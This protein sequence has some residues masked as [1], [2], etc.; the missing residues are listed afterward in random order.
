MADG[1]MLLTGEIFRGVH[2]L[3]ASFHLDTERFPALGTIQ[4]AI[5]RRVQAEIPKQYEEVGSLRLA[6]WRGGWQTDVAGR[7]EADIFE[8]R[9]AT[10][11]NIGRALVTVEVHR[12]G[13]TS[14]PLAR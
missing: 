2:D 13:R 5:E 14:E 9:E 1:Y 3:V 11:H 6:G 8:L 12:R 10:W 4:G 7:W